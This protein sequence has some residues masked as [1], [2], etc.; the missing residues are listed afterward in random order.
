MRMILCE[1]VIELR[2]GGEGEGKAEGKSCV[3]SILSWVTGEGKVLGVHFEPGV[4]SSSA[5]SSRG[6]IT[7][8]IS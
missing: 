3:T 6:L 5:F 2:W 1:G 7:I 4:C 8:V